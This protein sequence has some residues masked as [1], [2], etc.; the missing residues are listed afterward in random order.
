MVVGGCVDVCVAALVECI[1]QGSDVFVVVEVDDAG[2]LSTVSYLIHARIR[3]LS[4]VAAGGIRTVCVPR[5]S[6]TCDILTEE[7]RV[8]F[9]EI[10]EFL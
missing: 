8:G 1:Q 9:F 3:R 10:A 5:M 4:S 6:L 7:S 2:G